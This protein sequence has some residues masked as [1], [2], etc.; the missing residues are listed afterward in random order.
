MADFNLVLNRRLHLFRVMTSGSDILRT[1]QRS[2]V[3]VDKSEVFGSD[4]VECCR[5]AVSSVAERLVYTQ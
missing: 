2:T 4:P 3:L 1:I 5:G